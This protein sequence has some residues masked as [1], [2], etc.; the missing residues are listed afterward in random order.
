ML[1]L[2]AGGMMLSL[3]DGRK[4]RLAG[5]AAMGIIAGSAP[6][7]V[8]WKKAPISRQGWKVRVD[9]C[10]MGL[11]GPMTA[12]SPVPDCCPGTGNA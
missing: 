1:L 4:A 8:T 9:G 3:A 10:A 2:F 12:C 5:I 11:T 6:Q 7:A